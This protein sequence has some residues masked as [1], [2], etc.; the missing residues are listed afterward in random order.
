MLL[1]I[2]VLS[3]SNVAGPPGPQ[4]DGAPAVDTEDA[5]TPPPDTRLDVPTPD[6]P[7]EIVPALSC[8][9]SPL[10]CD[11]PFDQVAVA[12]THNGFATEEDGFWPPNQLHSMTRQLQDGV[13]CLMIDLHYDD[14]GIPSL[15]HGDCFW[16][17]RPLVEGFAEIRGFLDTDPGAVVTLILENYISQEDIEAAMAAGGLLGL[18]HPHPAGAPWPTLGE[19]VEAGERVVVLGP[20]GGDARPWL[21]DTWAAAFETD[22]N[23][24]VPEDLTCDVNRGSPDNALFILNHFVEDPLPEPAQAATV[25]FN[26]FFLERALGCLAERGHVP[27]FVTV[28]FYS[29][30]DVFDVVDTLNTPGR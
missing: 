12:C 8:N 26:P 7:P 14:D 27:N 23:N 28:D 30:G 17:Q 18:A 11:R 25:N 20:A 22:W 9:G 19:L 6:L 29:V 21:L 13:R 15:C 4:G 1:A 24:Q 16:G 10:L 5:P 2:S 3:C